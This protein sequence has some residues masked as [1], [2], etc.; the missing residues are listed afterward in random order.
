M[1]AAG[2]P[3]P[4][5]VPYR[6][7]LRDC[8]QVVMR[9]E[10]LRSGWSLADGDG[11]RR[12]PLPDA[13]ARDAYHRRIRELDSELAAADRTGNRVAAERAHTERQALVGELRRASAEEE[14]VRVNVTRTIRAAIDRITV[15][16]PI[17]GTHLQPSIR[18]SALCR[19]QPA[20]D[21]PAS[22][23]LKTGPCE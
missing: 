22:S 14:R 9:R 3:L 17:A 8:H 10:G 19:Y 5:S 6:H 16:A 15:A 11:G 23:R 13:A 1:L 20:P 18:T 21:G 12:L 4:P 7:P 2:Q